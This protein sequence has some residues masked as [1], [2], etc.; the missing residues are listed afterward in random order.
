[1]PPIIVYKYNQVMLEL[2]SKDFSFVGEGLT[3]ELYNI[4]EKIKFKPNLTQ[5]GAISLLCV[6]D[7]HPE[8][9]AQLALEAGLFFDVQVSHNL[10]LLTIRHYN[11]QII[12]ELCVHRSI[13][14][15]QQTQET[16]QVLM[17]T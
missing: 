6:V 1:M 5:N 12:S 11:Q 3:A 9:T 4:F 15:Q 10:T 17:K 2:N 8:K 13:I 7:E 16:M 14:L